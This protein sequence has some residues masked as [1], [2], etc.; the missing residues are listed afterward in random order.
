MKKVVLFI[1]FVTAIVTK[2][3][4]AGPPTY[5]IIL[6][7]IP[8][9]P[10][11]TATLE[12]TDGTTLKNVIII[13]NNEESDPGE[14]SL[15]FFRAPLKSAIYISDLKTLEFTKTEGEAGITSG[16]MLKISLKN[17]KKA[18][19]EYLSG[20][21]DGLTIVYKDDF[22]GYLQKLYIP[23]YKTVSGKSGKKEL[24]IKQMLFNNNAPLNAAKPNGVKSSVTR[25]VI[26]AKPVDVSPANTPLPPSHPE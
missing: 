11:L 22:S 21:N 7:E 23:V 3:A 17:G 6:D 16:D 13:S 20:L 18:T 25:R 9:Q 26:Q 5:P 2:S 4:F 24:Y 19:V 8:S 15:R 1:F 12:L 10:S 14:T